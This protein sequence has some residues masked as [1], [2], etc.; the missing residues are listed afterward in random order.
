[1]KERNH[2]LGS[3]PNPF[4][5]SF[6]GGVDFKGVTIVVTLF[7]YFLSAFIVRLQYEF[8]HA[9]LL[10]CFPLF[11]HVSLLLFLSSIASVP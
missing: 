6:H 10:A 3:A 9:G 2:Q 5:L 11:C 8:N 7:K 4:L 1:M